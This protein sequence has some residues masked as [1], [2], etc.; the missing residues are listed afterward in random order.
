MY[1][2]IVNSVVREKSENQKQLWHKH[3]KKILLYH[4]NKNTIYTHSSVHKLS[5]VQKLQL[6]FHVCQA[7]LPTIKL[8]SVHIKKGNVIVT[9]CSEECSWDSKPVR[10]QSI[11]STVYVVSVCVVC[12]QCPYCK[13]TKLRLI[14]AVYYQKAHP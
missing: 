2:Y 1:V 4:R 8:L 11:I 9:Q 13:Q 6:F 12:L 5:L 10:H 14:S 3:E 7:A